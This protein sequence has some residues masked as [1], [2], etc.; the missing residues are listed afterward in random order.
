[1]T[2]SGV[3]GAVGSARP[4][5]VAERPD[6]RLLAASNYHSDPTKVFL[7][8]T[9]MD[10]EPLQIDFERACNLKQA[11]S[12]FDFGDSCLIFEKSGPVC[13]LGELAFEVS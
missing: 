11:Y 8:H 4:G 12:R 3:G 1:M 13:A 5:G 7:N 2:E 9:Q 10:P 6:H